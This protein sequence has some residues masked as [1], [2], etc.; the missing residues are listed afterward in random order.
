MDL[1]LPAWLLKRILPGITF[2]MPSQGKNVYL[3]FDD[4]PHPSSTPHILEMLAGFN[5]KATFFCSGKQA[6]KY[7]RLLNAILD[8]GHATGNHSYSHPDGW[9]TGTDKYIA[10]VE[11]AGSIIPSGIFRPPYGRLTPAQYSELRKKYSIIMWTRQFADYKK[12]FNPSKAAV[13]NIAP[14]EVLVLHDSEKTS[15]RTLPLLSQLLKR[16]D[17]EGFSCLRLNMQKAASVDNADCLKQ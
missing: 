4:G 6:E 8:A 5:A 2:R 17:I 14:G 12:G 13:I 10:D 9:L 15:E 3:T 1:P 7:P 11:K 16:F